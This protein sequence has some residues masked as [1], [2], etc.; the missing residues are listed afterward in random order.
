MSNL[1]DAFDTF[2]DKLLLPD[3][4]EEKIRRAAKRL[5]DH[6]VRHTGVDDDQ[7]FLQGSFANNTTIRP[8]EDG[9]YDV[10]TCA[11]IIDD[12]DMTC[13]EAFAHLEEVLS[14]SED[15]GE[16]MDTS[17]DR[18]VRLE[19]A[20]DDIGGFH[21]DIV[22]AR[23]E[24]GGFLA[25]PV[26]GGEWSDTNPQ[27]FTD[28]CLE[29]PE[30][31]HRVLRML[32]RWRDNADEGAKRGVNSIVLQVLVADELPGNESDDAVAV[33]AVLE[34][35]HARLVACGGSKPEIEN[36]SMPDEDLAETWD[37]DDFDDFCDNVEEAASLA[38]QALSA[39]TDKESHD[40]WRTLFGDD[41]PK[42][43]GGDTQGSPSTGPFIHTGRRQPEQEAPSDERYG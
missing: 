31:F 41:F 13:D 43:P 22:A 5:H 37:D 10:D 36:P 40:L 34:G 6:V 28:W 2:H 18:C 38:R 39:V 21:V 11:V 26:R 3:H 27:G 32:K 15:Y 42:H 9:E 17:R 19:Y 23:D 1:P 14:Q 20:D 33:T 16:R 29:Q 7:V 8:L 4:A 12:R 24:P 35:M 30:M 25:I